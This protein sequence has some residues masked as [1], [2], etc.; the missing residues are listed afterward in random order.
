MER[1]T[2]SFNLPG[3]PPCSSH[4]QVIVWLEKS[5][6]SDPSLLKLSSEHVYITGLRRWQ[7]SFKLF[8][9]IM[10]N[11]SIFHINETDHCFYLDVKVNQHFQV[12]HAFLL[13]FVSNLLVKTPMLSGALSERLVSAM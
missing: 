8:L 4:K 3:I 13:H 1:R 6:R 9:A 7:D 12:K 2:E 11:F 5:V 10:E